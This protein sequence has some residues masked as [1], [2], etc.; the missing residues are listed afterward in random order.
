MAKQVYKDVSAEKF[1]E[2][3][4]EVVKMYGTPRDVKLLYCFEADPKILSG[5]GEPIEVLFAIGGMPKSVPNSQEP[6][7]LTAAGLS[8]PTLAKFDPKSDKA[9]WSFRKP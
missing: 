4:G 1:A 5:A 9:R 8:T 7:A 6:L 3:F 2:L